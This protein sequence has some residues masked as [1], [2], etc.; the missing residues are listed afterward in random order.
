[1]HKSPCQPRT[2]YVLDCRCHG[3]VAEREQQLL[4]FGKKIVLWHTTMEQ[5]Q[6]PT[7]ETW[8]LGTGRASYEG[9][10]ED[11][12]EVAMLLMNA[13]GRALPMA[14]LFGLHVVRWL[15]QLGEVRVSE[16]VGLWVA[17]CMNDGWVGACKLHRLIA[18]LRLAIGV[19]C[20]TT[21]HVTNELVAA[22]WLVRHV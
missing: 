10:L 14:E 22:Q 18:G 1:M 17:G 15:W 3:S 13:L 7:I 9:V 20:A 12:P 16:R 2:C 4:R 11:A 19:S 8:L 5:L 21:E 6:Q